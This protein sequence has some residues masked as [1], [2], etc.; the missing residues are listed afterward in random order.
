MLSWLSYPL[1]KEG[2]YEHAGPSLPHSVLAAFAAKVEECGTIT[3][4]DIV[5]LAKLARDQARLHRLDPRG[6]CEEF[7]KLA[8]EH[9]IA[10]IPMVNLPPQSAVRRSRVLGTEFLL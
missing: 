2:S 6:S 7:C 9:G 8:L 1:R 5:P 10:G 4:G 3:S